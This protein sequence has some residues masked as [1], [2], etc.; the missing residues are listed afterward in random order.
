MKALLVLPCW[1]AALPLL[2]CDAHGVSLGSEDLCVLDPRFAAL[3]ADAADEKVSNCATLGEN[4]LV[5]ASFESPVVVD[6]PD[7]SFCQFP[8]ADVGGWNT[9]SDTQVIEIWTDGW[10]DVPSP[11]GGQFAELDAESQDTLWQD[12][13]LTPGQLMYWS[14]LHRGR[15]DVETMEVR[16]GPPEATRSQ[17]VLMSPTGAWSSYS[18]LYRVGPAE[19]RTRIELASLTGTTDGNLVDAVVFAPVE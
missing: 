10:R 6:C 18:G 8:A 15:H 4:V 7:G 2:G 12:V 3:M 9:N 16:I 19:T 13:A 14:L 11:D 1:V 5:N 17:E